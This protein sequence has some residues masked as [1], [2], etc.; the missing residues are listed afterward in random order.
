MRERILHFLINFPNAHIYQDGPDQSR[1]R[2][3]IQVPHMGDRSVHL[4]YCLFFPG[5][6]LTGLYS[7]EIEAK[8]EPSFS[9]VGCCHPKHCLHCWVRYLPLAFIPIYVLV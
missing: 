8:I 6:V 7:Q 5:S 3:L 9:N 2:N 4:S 1:A